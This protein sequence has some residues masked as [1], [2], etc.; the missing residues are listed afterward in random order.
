MQPCCIMN[1]YCHAT[2]QLNG[3]M[4]FMQ[5]CDIMDSMFHATVQHNGS[6]RFLHL[7]SIQ[8]SSNWNGLKIGSNWSTHLRWRR[9]PRHEAAKAHRAGRYRRYY[10]RRRGID[11]PTPNP[12]PHLEARHS[13]NTPWAMPRRARSSGLSL[14][15]ENDMTTGGEPATF[16]TESLCAETEPP[17]IPPS[18]TDL[19]KR[20]TK[21]VSG[22]KTKKKWYTKM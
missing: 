11:R 8:D 20:C 1:L 13:P 7:C 16:L 5:P 2:V 4:C 14:K 12:T 19:T 21:N 18:T 17:R 22:A 10:L 3:F 9:P 15:P 6:T